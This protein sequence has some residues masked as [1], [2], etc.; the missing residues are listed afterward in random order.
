MILPRSAP[1]YTARPKSSVLNRQD[2]A[3]FPGQ[4]VRLGTYS[5]LLLSAAVTVLSGDH[6]WAA[7]REGSIPVW[8][9]LIPPA[10]FTAFV[11][12]YT[13][14]RWL[15]VRRRAYPLGRALFQVAFAVVFLTLLLP[16]QAHELRLA[17]E[18]RQHA[19]QQPAMLLLSHSDPNVRAA[20]CALLTGNFA[21]EVYEHVQTMAHH[22]QVPRVRADCAH[23]L[24]RLHAAANAIG[25]E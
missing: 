12:I 3:S 16:Q 5:M 1:A 8:A 7:S 22:D 19:P 15:L 25:H 6:L 23:A 11:A 20:A 9:P 24:Q 18:E 4:L 10:A 17:R 21:P 2:P 13:C 14:D